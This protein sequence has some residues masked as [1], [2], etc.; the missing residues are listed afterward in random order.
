MFALLLA[1][2]PLPVAAQTSFPMITHTHPVAVQRGRAS[3]VTIEGQQ[4]FAGAY[5]LLIEG[6]GVAGE[7]TPA[8]AANGAKSATRS[9]KAKM[10]VAADA[11]LGTREFRVAST[12]GLSSLGQIVVV[13]EPVVVESGPNNTP[14]QATPVTLPCV[15]CGRIE[16]AEDVDCFKF[17]ARAGQ[18]LTFEVFGARLEDKIHDLQKHLD[19]LIAL[20]DADGRELAANDDALF[21]DSLL[22]Y[23]VPKDGIYILQIRAAK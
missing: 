5:K 7:V 8:P 20:L 14:A 2:V 11:P 13:D 9:I 6:T 3:E 16:V 23:T 19:P 21:S 17:P 15:V 1:A 18:T 10:T 12:L 22:T 4:N